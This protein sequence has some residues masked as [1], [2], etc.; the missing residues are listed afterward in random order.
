MEDSETVPV[1]NEK[2]KVVRA[3]PEFRNGLSSGFS[4]MIQRSLGVGNRCA[5]SCE[6]FTV[7]DATNF[8]RNSATPVTLLVSAWKILDRGASR[9][10][11]RRGVPSGQ[12]LVDVAPIG[13]VTV[14]PGH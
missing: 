8:E 13:R 11:L 3:S 14:R 12:R 7:S 10:A 1:L 6:C 5:T 9:L 4:G 2:R